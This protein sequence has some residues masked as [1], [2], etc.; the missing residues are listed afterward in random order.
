MNKVLKYPW[1]T[2]RSGKENAIAFSFL[3][4]SLAGVALFYIIPFFTS[5]SYATTDR[6]GNFVGIENF[7]N[8]FHSEAFR[9]AS[10]NTFRFMIIAI[11][12]SIIIPLFLACLLFHLKGMGWLKTILMSPLVI[13]TA[14]TAFFFQ[15]LFMSNGFVSRLL[16]V[17][18]DWLQTN[19]AFT[20][21]IG[22]YI[23]KNLGFNLVLALAARANIPNEYYE[24]SAV[25]GMGKI[26]MFFKITLVYLV[27]GLFIMLVMSFINSFRIYRELYMLSGNY[28]HDSIYMLQHYM[29]NQFMWINRQNLTSSAFIITFVITAFMVAFFIIDKKYEYGE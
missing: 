26:R 10:W 23:W 21:A 16:N 12:L 3:I 2:E 11:P 8:L 5:L 24:W 7:T 6:N 18:T 19:H 27:P 1:T 29:N 9:L 13:P 22:L 20:I 25:E 17:N 15:S 4:P 28:P 14:S